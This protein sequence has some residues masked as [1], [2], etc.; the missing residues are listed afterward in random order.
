[1][2][3]QAAKFTHTQ[4][5]GT[6]IAELRLPCLVQRISMSD[7]NLGNEHNLE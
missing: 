3:K 2:N 4:Q 1:M 6:G 7:D 5:P